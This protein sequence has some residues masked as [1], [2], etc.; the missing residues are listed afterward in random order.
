M[1]KTFK[2]KL[3]KLGWTQAKLARSIQEKKGGKYTYH[4][5]SISRWSK[6]KAVPNV[7]NFKLISDI[8]G[9]T[10]EETYELFS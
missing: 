7:F 3:A 9:I 10:M 4:E 2:E 5:Q 8:L 1:K 6:N